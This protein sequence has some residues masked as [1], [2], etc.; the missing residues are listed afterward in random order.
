M[1]RFFV[2]CRSSRDIE[3]EI[4]HIVFVIMLCDMERTEEMRKMY[5]EQRKVKTFSM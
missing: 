2:I 1:S 4:F 3:K 5:C